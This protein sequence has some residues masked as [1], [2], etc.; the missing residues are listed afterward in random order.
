[1]PSVLRLKGFDLGSVAGVDETAWLPDD[2]L[3]AAHQAAASGFVILGGDVW[4]RSAS[5]GTGSWSPAYEN[6]Y[7]QPV[8]GE[9][10]EDFIARGLQRTVEFIGRYRQ[11]VADENSWF[12]LVCSRPDRWLS[13]SAYGDPEPFD[14]LESLPVLLESTPWRDASGRW[15]GGIK[16]IDSASYEWLCPHRHAS[17][18][19]AFACGQGRW[20][21]LVASKGTNKS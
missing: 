7:V 18:E 19:E 5:E 6:W 1:M 13:E 21:D 20:L 2:A 10:G 9:S 11:R 16:R 17:H 4:T 15:R 8:K 3:D 12:V 14:R